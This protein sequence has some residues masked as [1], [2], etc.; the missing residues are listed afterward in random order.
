MRAW[1]SARQLF[2]DSP[3]TTCHSQQ[4]NVLAILAGAVPARIERAVMERVLA[5]TTLTPASYYFSFDTLEALRKAGL[6]ERDIEQLEP[7]QTMLKLGMKSAQEKPEPTSS[8]YHACA[9]LPNNGI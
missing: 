2:R 9:A 8:D 4:T 7:W 6:G 1:D 3:D 5:D